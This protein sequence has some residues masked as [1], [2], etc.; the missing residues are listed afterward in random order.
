MSEIG[1]IFSA[2][3][4]S[5]TIKKLKNLESSTKA[6]DDRGIKYKSKNGGTHLIIES[7]GK[8]FAD[9]WPSTG[10]YKLRTSNKYKRGVFKLIRELN[11]E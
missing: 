11:N 5:R 9:F 6:L 4:E 1:E 2:L 10:K 7:D 8:D 3:K